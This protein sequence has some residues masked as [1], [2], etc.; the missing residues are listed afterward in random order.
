MQ[1]RCLLGG[2][3]G[4]RRKA[5]ERV[6]RTRRSRQ[7]GRAARQCRVGIRCHVVSG[8][9]CIGKEK[10]K[11]CKKKNNI[12]FVYTYTFEIFISL[13]FCRNRNMC[14]AQV[15]DRCPVYA[16]VAVDYRRAG[17]QVETRQRMTKKIMYGD[18]MKNKKKN[19]FFLRNWARKV[20]ET[21]TNCV[22]IGI[23]KKIFFFLVVRRLF[24]RMY[25]WEF[26]TENEFF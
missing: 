9:G 7:T 16:V 2:C 24:L 14:R 22:K 25:L 8:T 21:I 4:V 26:A 15:T 10:N 1:G 6:G 11:I 19:F 3:C 20:T 5:G 13:Y 18:E 12:Y 23:R 17:L